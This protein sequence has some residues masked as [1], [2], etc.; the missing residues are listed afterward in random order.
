MVLIVIQSCFTFQVIFKNPA[1]IYLVLFGIQIALVAIQL[2]ILCLS[3][4]WH[5]LISIAFLLLANYF[6]LF[7]IARDY[8]IAKRIYAG[9]NAINEKFKNQ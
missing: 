9:E 3:R 8:L 1:L 6:T 5:N 2:L 4:E 7:K